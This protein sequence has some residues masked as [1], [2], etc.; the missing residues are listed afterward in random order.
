MKAQFLTRDTTPVDALDWATLRWLS[1]PAQTQARGLV[2]VEV[3]IKPGAGHSFHIHPDQEEL[4]YVL[5]GRIEQWL[6]KETRELQAGD[7]AFIPAGTVHASF[8]STSGP[9]RLL[10]ILSPSVKEQGYEAVDV[11]GQEPWS[12]LRK[13]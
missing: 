6:E 8:N 2:I 9:A 7:S 4:I 13:G 5:Q 10:A 1:G 12:S 3:D 11:S